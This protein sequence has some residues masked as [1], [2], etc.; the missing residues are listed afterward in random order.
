MNSRFLVRYFSCGALVALAVPVMCLAQ[1]SST[2]YQVEVFGVG[3]EGGGVATSSQYQVKGVVGSTFQRPPV[4]PAADGASD[5]NNTSGRQSRNG[6]GFQAAPSTISP[7]VISP[8]RVMA[9]PDDGQGL[10][11]SPD[12]GSRETFFDDYGGTAEAS[13]PLAEEG[14]MGGAVERAEPDAAGESGR[15]RNY[16]WVLSVA[17]MVSVVVFWY[18]NRARPRSM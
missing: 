17:V 12:M 7:E 18:W 8:E 5:E 1:L 14:S 6:E 15:P 13:S 9:E 10:A 3:E 4:P 16:W 11:S 2:N